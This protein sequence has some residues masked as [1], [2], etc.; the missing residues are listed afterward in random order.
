MQF[1]YPSWSWYPC[2]SAV[3]RI[4]TGTFR[5]KKNNNNNSKDDSFFRLTFNVYIDV[6]NKERARARDKK[7]RRPISLEFYSG[8]EKNEKC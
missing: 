7:Q 1:K 4:A 2:V 8:G 3:N 6:D 5:D